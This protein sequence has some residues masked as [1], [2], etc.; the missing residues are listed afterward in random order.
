MET[1]SALLE[2]WYLLLKAMEGIEY[3]FFVHQKVYA[4]LTSIPREKISVVSSVSVVP[5]EEFDA[6]VVNTLH[7]NF[8]AY[9]AVFEKKPTLCLLHNLN[10]S[11]FFKRLNLSNCFSGERFIYYLK[12]HLL[13][14]VGERRK[15]VLKA[16]KFGVLSKALLESVKADGRYADKTEIIPMHYCNEASFPKSDVIHIVMPGN[17][18][19]KRKEVAMLFDILPKLQPVSKLHFTFLG[20]P[21]NN[22][23][24]R[25]LEHL[26][27]KCHANVSVTHYHRFIP[28]E[29][30]SSVI[31]QAHLLLCPI[32]SKTS[33]YWVD[34]VYGHTKVSGSETDCIYNGK[35]G[36]FPKS[37]PKMDWHNLYY[38]T[39]E[40][41]ATQL[42]TLNR[43]QLEAEYEKLAPFVKQHTFERVKT[44]LENQLLALAD[45]K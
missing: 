20:K 8:D 19:N 21:E 4:K 37:Y 17:V 6:V 23:V 38:A 24:L 34:E 45:S 2:Q 26:Q 10:F 29:E 25:E 43:L 7:R 14:S 40:D 32:K 30:Y 5:V 1:H 11:L 33:F 16:A 28:W 27:Q 44:H 13:E 31:S 3:R 35:I 18:S 36:L 42:N 22:L 41:L 39:P 15:A 12:L 9:A